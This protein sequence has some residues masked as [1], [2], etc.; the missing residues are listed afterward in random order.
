MGSK[1]G[2]LLAGL[3]VIGVVGIILVMVVFPSASPATG[4]TL[5]EGVLDLHTVGPPTAV[6]DRQPT[7]AGNAGDDYKKAVDLYNANVDVIARA[8][9]DR[10]RIARGQASL[11]S[12]TMKILAD[13]AARLAAGARKKEMRYTLVHTPKKFQVGYFYE[14]AKD[15][16]NVS[17]AVMLLAA[18]HYARKEYAE[19]Q[20]AL[21]NAFVVGWHMMNERSRMDLVSIGL[22][23]QRDAIG[24]LIRLYKDW[25][26]EDRNEKISALVAHDRRLARLSNFYD[27]KRRVIWALGKGAHPGDVFNII[28]NDE[29]RACR[30]QGLLYLGVL[31]FTAATRGDIRKTRRLIEKYAGSDDPIEKAAAIAARDM[32]AEEKK[33]LWRR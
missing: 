29:D 25:P 16:R 31:R 26:G 30:A 4:A 27:D 28:E 18:Q 12:S 21:R 9:A 1:L 6:L 13:I 15:L 2:W 20:K 23:I 17:A 33:F 5:K 22:G 8:E 3:L 32:T 19:A 24:G 14:P 10:Q 7:A 11:D